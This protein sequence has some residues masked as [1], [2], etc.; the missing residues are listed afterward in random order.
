MGVIAR[1][2]LKIGWARMEVESEWWGLPSKEDDEGGKRGQKRRRYRSINVLRA[3]IYFFACEMELP[4][5]TKFM[6]FSVC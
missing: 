1:E 4:R 6:Q 5:G 2:I 3:S